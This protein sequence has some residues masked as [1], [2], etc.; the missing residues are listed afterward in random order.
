MTTILAIESS[1]LVAGAAIVTDEKVVAE[2]N[3]NLKMTHSQTLL[4]MIDEI[5]KMSGI[6]LKDITAI[7]VSGGPGSFTGLRIGSATAKGLGLALNK[8]IVAVPT[9]QGL[10]MNIFGFKGLIC[11][12]MDA[13]RNQ[14]YTGVYRNYDDFEIIEDQMALPLDELVDRL[15]TS[16]DE[17]VMFVGDGVPVFRDRIKERMQEKCMFAIENSMYQRAGSLGLRALE[18]YKAGAFTSAEQHAPDYL[19]LSQAER[20]KNE[21]SKHEN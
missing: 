2:Y 10:A 9:T 6:E 13:R 12:I 14:V 16:Y 1:G 5:V 3:V 7:A 11:P 4:P 8:P 17:N 15:L 20:E 18:L 19:R 21:A